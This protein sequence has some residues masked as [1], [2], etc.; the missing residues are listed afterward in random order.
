MKLQTIIF[1]G[2]SGSGKGTQADLL[3]KY[4]KENDSEHSAI[5]YETGDKVREF[6]TG[7][8]YV[9]KLVDNTIRN[10]ELLP[11]SFAIWTWVT[12][13]IENLSE[14]DH[15]IFDGLARKRREAEIL[16]ETLVYLKRLKPTIILLNTSD[17]CALKR[18]LDRGR[19]DDDKEKIL[20]R[21]NWYVKETTPAMA[22]FENNP[23]YNF[24]TIDGNKSIDEVH[25]S[26]IKS[27]SF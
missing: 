13:M 4:L 8:G 10:G 7:D 1:Y 25:E 6:A 19:N 22:V 26:V 17:E 5:S 2:K 14:N 12:F 20:K 23:N 24:V 3:K 27:L 15:V 21:L 16:D 18:L 11:E 9:N